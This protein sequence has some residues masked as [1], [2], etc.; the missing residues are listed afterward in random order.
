MQ[1]Y[2]HEM[3]NISV[4]LNCTEHVHGC[5]TVE[6]GVQWVEAYTKVREKRDRVWQVL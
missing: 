1:L 4:D 3:R 6:A 2:V 5:M